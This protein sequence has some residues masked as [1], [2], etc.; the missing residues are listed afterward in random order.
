MKK[1]FRALLLILFILIVGVAA[2]GIYVKT[3]LP[4][5]GSAPVIKVDTTPVRVERGRY[6]ANNVLLCLDCHT[7]HDYSFYGGPLIVG[8]TGGGG[9]EFG[10]DRGCPGT[11]FS[12]NITP[13]A[14]A[15][16]T[17]GEI[18]RAITTGV[19]KNG[20]ALFPLMPY[21]AYGQM[22]QEDIYSIIA[23]LRTL[24]PVKNDFPDKTLDFPL[25]FIAGLTRATLFLERSLA[26]GGISHSPMAPWLLRQT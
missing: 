11:I 14:L 9:E 24:P 10:K 1:F 16:W 25:N 26:G 8:A 22:D 18:F 6:L 2:I 12:K 17:D 3:G 13:Y 5:V 19:N 15:N 20:K 4:N 7:R 23:Y 21:P